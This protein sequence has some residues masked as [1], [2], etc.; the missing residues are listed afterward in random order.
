MSIN[1]DTFIENYKKVA[2]VMLGKGS[3]QATMMESLKD[4]FE[5]FQLSS[6]QYGEIVGQIV[7][8][9]AVSFNKDAIASLDLVIKAQREEELKE[10]QI[11]VHKRKVQ[12]YDDNMLLKIVEYQSSITSFAINANS[13]S[14]Q[15][16]INTLKEKMAKVE[17]R[18]LGIDGESNCPAIPLVVPPPT[19]LIATEIKSVTSS[20]KWND[21]PNATSYDLYR[22][23]QLIST[24][25]GLSFEDTGLTV[26]TKY[27]YAVRASIR[28]VLS[29]Y[30]ETI[31][32]LTVEDIL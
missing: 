30:S 8:T 4:V 10:A 21:V 27:A 24:S 7:S 23:G 19:G 5:D 26:D 31:V 32:V 16:T 13:T 22:D 20:I 3:I 29:N 12:G 11:L 25:S 6:E 9:T 1:I 14:A 17:A 2:L 15:E 18:V 28:G